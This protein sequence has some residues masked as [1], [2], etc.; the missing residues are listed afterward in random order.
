MLLSKQPEHAGYTTKVYPADPLRFDQNL[1]D[2]RAKNSE[3]LVFSDAAVCKLC[4]GF[5]TNSR[6]QNRIVQGRD[7]PILFTDRISEIK[8]ERESR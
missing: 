7:E 3:I 2:K 5:A 6:P 1:Q 4:K 8:K